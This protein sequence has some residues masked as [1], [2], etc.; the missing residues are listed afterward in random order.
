[1]Y[2]GHLF[3]VGMISFLSFLEHAT[4]LWMATLIF[5]VLL[6]YL[7]LKKKKSRSPFHGVPVVPNAHWLLGHAPRLFSAENVSKKYDEL[8]VRHANA[9][10]LCS[11]WLGSSPMLS[12]TKATDIQNILK[13]NSKHFDFTI[14]SYHFKKFVSSDQPLVHVSSGKVWRSKR[15]HFHRV[16]ARNLEYSNPRFAE[17]SVSLAKTMYQD[18]GDDATTKVYEF[19]HLMQLAVLDNFGMLAFGQDLGCCKSLLMKGFASSLNALYGD[20]T[21]RI[22]N[23]LNPKAIFYW[24]PSANNIARYHAEVAVKKHIAKIVSEKE[25]ASMTKDGL[26]SNQGCDLVSLLMQDVKEGKITCQ[27]VFEFLQE[28]FS[29]TFLT[30]SFVIGPTLWSIARHPRIEELCLEEIHRVIGSNDLNMGCFFEQL[31]YCRAVLL[32][33]LR[34]YPSVPATTR[35]LEKEVVIGGTTYLPGTNVIIPIWNAH[36]DPE[37]FPRPEEFLPE[38]WVKLRHDGLWE[39]RFTGDGSD[40]LYGV[41]PANR[42]AFIAFSA[43][44]RNCI[45]QKFALN[46]GVMLLAALLREFK[47]KPVSESELDVWLTALTCEVKNGMFLSLKR[48]YKSNDKASS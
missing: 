24:L 6:V 42:N 40:D 35:S 37:N 25:N 29:A 26:T 22:N 30:L 33:A 16:I 15:A 13:N 44:G 45:G 19:F 34:M 31:F 27:A 5:P 1:M 43:G 20:F 3:T 23:M 2:S 12:V 17:I 8:F 14:L 47:I 39:E 36:R 9:Q 7:Y 32:E 21:W 28:A 48:R 11:T 10:G 38:R 18:L 41:P 46:Q 4:F